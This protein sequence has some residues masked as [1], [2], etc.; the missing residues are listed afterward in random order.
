ML[1]GL[2]SVG[3]FIRDSSCRLSFKLVIVSTVYSVILIKIST[4]NHVILV[5]Q[6]NDDNLDQ[7]KVQSPYPCSPNDDFNIKHQSQ[8]I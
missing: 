4:N 7:R 8:Q 2:N 3:P 6:L 1:R 5:L